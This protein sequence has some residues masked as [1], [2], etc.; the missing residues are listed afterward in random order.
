M[1]RYVLISG[2]LCVASLCAK[3]QKG[4]EITVVNGT[5]HEMKVAL[6]T[7]YNVYPV[8][9]YG[10]SYMSASTFG[11]HQASPWLTSWKKIKK[12]ET[13][14]ITL[15]ADAVCPE[16]LVVKSKCALYGRNMTEF[17]E[18]DAVK[19]VEDTQAR[20][21]YSAYYCSGGKTVTFAGLK[22]K[23]KR[24]KKHTCEADVTVSGKLE[25]RK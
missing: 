12:G 11:P 4:S 25:I 5:S 1:K 23:S 7:N 22:K 15:S 13:K 21:Q 14:R 8:P 3:T 18:R 9:G 17:E 10:G 19:L 6:A 24:D 2:L 16:Y 20:G